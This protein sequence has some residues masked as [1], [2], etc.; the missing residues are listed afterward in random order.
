MKLDDV[1]LARAS[2]AQHLRPGRNSGREVRLSAPEH[3]AFPELP[4]GP[5]EIVEQP[6]KGFS[7][8]LT[9][10]LAR[11]K[12]AQDEPVLVKLDG[13]RHRFLRATVGA[14]RNDHNSLQ[15]PPFHCVQIDRGFWI[16]QTELVELALALP[17]S[18]ADTPTDKTRRPMTRA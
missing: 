14:R 18:N 15:L 11:P 5:P 16:V 7:Q 1:P 9:Q 2:E 3:L 13:H 10:G 17:R 12:P 8:R 6:R 4:I